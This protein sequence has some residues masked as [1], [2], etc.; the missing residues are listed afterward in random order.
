M[1]VVRLRNGNLLIPVTAQTDDVIGDTVSEITPD[2]PLFATWQK[3][4]N[5]EQEVA[6]FA[7]RGIVGAEY[8]KSPTKSHTWQPVD[9]IPLKA[10]LRDISEK[11]LQ[12]ALVELFDELSPDVAAKIE[13]GEA[14]SDL[15]LSNAFQKVI[16]PHLIE[17]ATEEAIRLG[18]E[19]AFAWDTPVVNMA[20]VEWA[21]EYSYELVRNLTETSR[22]VISNAIQKY[23][24]TPGMTIGDVQEL[25][26]PAFGSVR[27]EAISVTEITRSYSEGMN[28]TQREFEAAG[29]HME[30]VWVT[31]RDE[32]V[33]PICAP[34]N[35]KDE[36][37]WKASRPAGPPAHPRC[38]CS[39]VLRH[40]PEDA[41]KFNPYHDERGR[42]TTMQ[43]M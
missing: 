1:I 24:L 30:R 27:A 9:L 43:N 36:K 23:A 6:K 14:V 19:F 40:V 16:E 12:K 10:N 33:C 2:D 7:Y 29:V 8:L 34:L 32:K 20:M 41:T 15:E 17:A 38:R 26:K 21:K 18:A 39:S 11:R 22:K 37:V 4:V 25:L 31:N 5:R 3:F 35:G 28:F 13:R 42:F